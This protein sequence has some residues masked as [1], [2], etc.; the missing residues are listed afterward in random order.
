MPVF[1]SRRDTNSLELMDDPNC[2][3]EELN[4]TYRQFKVINTLISRW[5]QIYEKEIRPRFNDPS[6]SYSILD[7]GF[8]GGDIP[9]KLARWTLEDGL[10]V[11]ITGIETNIRAYRFASSLV[12]PENVT[13]LFKSSGELL[14]SGKK[15]DVVISNHL[16]HHLD[17][18]AFF[19]TLSEAQHLSKKAVFFNDIERS[20]IGYLLFNI[21]SRPVFGSSFITSDGLTSIKRSY[22]LNE[23][24][25]TVP[26][27]WDVQRLFP[28]RLLLSYHHE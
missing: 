28:Y 25:Q 24:K 26:P 21:L 9:L 16:L 23:L 27:G 20:D 6:K 13:Y 7:I 22:T 18:E 4:N 15:Y 3:I 5:R 8:G 10:S 2:D 17:R 19:K 11:H 14:D 1:L 12:T